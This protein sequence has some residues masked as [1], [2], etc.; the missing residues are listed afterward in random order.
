MIHQKNLSKINFPSSDFFKKPLVNELCG[1]FSSQYKKEIKNEKDLSQLIDY[2]AY[3]NIV[4]DKKI[5]L[6]KKTFGFGTSDSIELKPYSGSRTKAAG[7]S[8][9]GDGSG[10]GWIKAD[11]KTPL[12]TADIHTCATINLVDEDSGQ[13]FLYHVYRGVT[14]GTAPIEIEKFLLKEFP[15]FTKVNII[16]GDQQQTNIAVNN[17][18]TALFNINKET[19]VQFYHFSSKNPEVVAQNGELS[20]IERDGNKMTFTEVKNNFF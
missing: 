9:E 8:T 19:K 16:P 13:Q 14:K 1:D 7:F 10:G 18:L 15:N 3:L 12:S 20:Y 5:R 17:A 6:E 11:I 4:E 2:R